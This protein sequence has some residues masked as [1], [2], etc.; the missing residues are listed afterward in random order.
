VLCCA[1]ISHKSGIFNSEH[2]NRLCFTVGEH[3]CV[4]VVCVCVCVCVGVCLF[5][6]LFVCLCVCVCGVCV[7]VC[8]DVWRAC[9]IIRDC[10]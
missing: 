1:C 5:V 6:C 8:S 9:V 2:N 4:C 10:L 3:Q 7:F